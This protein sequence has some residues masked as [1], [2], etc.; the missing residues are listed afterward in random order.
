MTVTKG[1]KGGKAKKSFKEKQ[2]ERIKKDLEKTEGTADILS[3][4]K[5]LGGKYKGTRLSK[6]KTESDFDDFLKMMEQLPF[7][8]LLGKVSIDRITKGQTTNK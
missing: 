8:G 5:E 4:N 1:G 7:D 2:K 6:G 3:G